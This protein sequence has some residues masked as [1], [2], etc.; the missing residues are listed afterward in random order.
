MATYTYAELEG[1]WINAGGPRALAPIAAAIAEAESGGNSTALNPSDNGGTQSS[2]GLWQISNGTHTPPSPNWSDPAVNAQLAV[3]KWKGAGDAFSPWGTY[4]SGAYKRFLSG[5]TTPNTN[6]PG[7]GG[8]AGGTG[9]GGTVPAATLLSYSPA[10]CM[11]MFPGIPV[12]FLGNIGSFCILTKAEVRSWIG[13]GLL[14]GGAV[15]M[16]PGAFL[17]AAAAGLHALGAGG[18]VLEKTGAAVALIPGAEGAGVAIAAAGRAGTSS[19]HATQ[20]RRAARRNRGGGQEQ[21][22]ETFSTEPAGPA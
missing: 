3:G 11:W 6:V 18:P 16:L 1:L 12:P 10:E 21:E 2:F 20:R 5:R 9:T 19:A 8:S 7:G 4:V 15:M 22:G 13:A 14:V 17:L